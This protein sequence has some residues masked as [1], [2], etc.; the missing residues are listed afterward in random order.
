MSEPELA[1]LTAENAALHVNLTQLRVQVEQLAVKLDTLQY[2]YDL[3]FHNGNQLKDP[4]RNHTVY[5]GSG[6]HYKL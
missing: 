3:H 4:Q 6:G 2:N 5:V 1:R